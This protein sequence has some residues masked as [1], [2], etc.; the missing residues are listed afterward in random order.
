LRVIKVKE[1]IPYFLQS[2][3]L[4]DTI[5]DSYFGLGLA[6][7]NIKEYKLAIEAFCECVKIDN[8]Y[9][10]TYFK[11]AECYYHT[12]EYDLAIY[13]YGKSLESFEDYVTMMKNSNVIIDV[14]E[15][16]FELQFK[17]SNCFVCIEG[18]YFLN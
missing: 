6:Y 8:G 15:T 3:K 14:Q 18:I 1:S 13:D 11:R 17:Y 7:L 9:I 10:M 16:Y 4:D 12:G 2:T 5:I